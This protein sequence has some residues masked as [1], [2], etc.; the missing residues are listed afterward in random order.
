MTG[1]IPTLDGLRQDETAY[2]LMYCNL[3]CQEGGDGAE[4]EA[5]R[6]P[7]NRPA[8]LGDDTLQELAAPE[9]ARAWLLAL[10]AQ[11][12]D[13]LDTM[14][15]AVEP[16]D[17]AERAQVVDP[18]LIASDSQEAARLHNYEAR[19]TAAFLRAHKRLEETLKS[20]AESDRQSVA[21]EP[22]R[23]AAEPQQPSKPAPASAAEATGSS[24]TQ[25]QP[26]SATAPAGEKAILAIEPTDLTVAPAVRLEQPSKPATAAA[27]AARPAAATPILLSRDRD[28]MPEKRFQQPNEGCRAGAD[29]A[30][31]A[32]GS[33]PGG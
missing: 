22:V 14:A 32:S 21:A 4:L 29:R 3:R 25:P 30:R 28:P 6:R 23:P 1:V 17:L 13:E 8:A 10:V 11:W 15:S 19:T 33:P 18:N 31:A 20:D 5:L 2:L 27:S 26:P 9:A 16:K 12:I 24:R 7:E